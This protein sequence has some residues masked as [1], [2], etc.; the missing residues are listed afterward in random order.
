MSVCTA[1]IELVGLLAYWLG[2]LSPDEE[3]AIEEHFLGCA[4]CAERLGYLAALAAGVREAVRAGTVS[5][6]ISPV[7][8]EALRQAGLRLREYR[9][10]P[11]GA[12][13]CTIRAQ[14][15]GVLSRLEAPLGGVERVD[16]VEL[17]W[18]T[19]HED[20]PFDSA[21]GEVLF[22]PSAEALR[23]MPAHVLNVQLIAMGPAGEKPLGEYRFVHT[24][25]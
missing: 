22:L 1:P 5:T 2:E 10:A 23:R 19:R 16:L 4:D 21:A 6:V 8:L 25:G 3:A 24:P 17:E 14:D 18:G 12:V 7:L 9:V 11:G 20:I 15:D 13:D